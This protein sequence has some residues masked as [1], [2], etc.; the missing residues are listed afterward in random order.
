MILNFLQPISNEYHKLTWNLNFDFRSF[1]LQYFV[2][3]SIEMEPHIIIITFPFSMAF[4]L[5]NLDT[6]KSNTENKAATTYDKRN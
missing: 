4:R 1:K 6:D 2:G 3:H 5:T